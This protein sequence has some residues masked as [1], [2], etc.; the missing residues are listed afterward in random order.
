MK[1]WLTEAM[2][3]I[4]YTVTSVLW[5][6]NSSVSWVRLL[7]NWCIESSPRSVASFLPAVD[8][9]KC[10]WQPWTLETMMIL[11]SPW[12]CRLLWHCLGTNPHLIEWLCT[13]PATKKVLP[14][15][16]QHNDHII[17]IEL[18]PAGLHP[19]I[20]LRQTLK[21]PEDIQQGLG[22]IKKRQTAD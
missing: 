16:N 14:F 21:N 6:C 1:Q 17:W 9:T 13:L 2:G 8:E 11:V 5:W 15:A 3:W 22:Q 4:F 19:G 10:F 12:Q 20:T 18:Q 7:C